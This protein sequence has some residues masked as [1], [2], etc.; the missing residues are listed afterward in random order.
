MGPIQYLAVAAAVLL[1][2]SG[3]IVN[4]SSVQNQRTAI[5]LDAPPSVVNH[6]DVVTFTGTL[7]NPD[8]GEGIPDKSVKIYREGPIGPELIAE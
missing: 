1:L 5:T 6:N 3:V 8:T 2:L 4:A 7:I